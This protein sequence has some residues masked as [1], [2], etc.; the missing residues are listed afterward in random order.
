MPGQDTLT[1]SVNCPV[2]G[3][4]AA[5]PAP[6]GYLAIIKIINLVP[7]Y[8]H[9]AARI[10]GRAPV[11]YVPRSRG[12]SGSLPRSERDD[13][14]PI[15]R[16]C[17]CIL[18]AVAGSHCRQQPGSRRCPCRGPSGA[19]GAIP[20]SEAGFASRP[21]LMPAGV[22]CLDRRGESAAMQLPP[23]GDNRRKV[24]LNRPEMASWRLAHTRRGRL[25]GD[26][27]VVETDPRTGRAII[28]C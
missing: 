15:S 17:P 16:L 22:N 1:R 24:P 3:I 25:R 9:R 11:R 28:D 13:R 5:K 23:I 8:G 20:R 6:L 14:D 4:R 21:T 19:R 7:G 26:V 10:P 27:P 18:P 2:P 12:R